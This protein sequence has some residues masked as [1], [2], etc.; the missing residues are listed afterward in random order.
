MVV[1]LKL[2]SFLEGC[3]FFSRLASS[4]CFFV[5][6]W[7]LWY[8]KGFSFF[9]WPEYTG[10]RALGLRNRKG[11]D[12]DHQVC[13]RGQC[14]LSP[15]L[16][17]SVKVAWTKL[18][19]DSASRPFEVSEKCPRGE[20]LFAFFLPFSITLLRQSQANVMPVEKEKCKLDAVGWK[21]WECRLPVSKL[22]DKLP[23]ASL[24][25]LVPFSM[26]YQLTKLKI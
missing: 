22:H 19:M 14:E 12:A 17:Q 1:H 4:G 25:K 20:S 16:L 2:P 24:E 11:T 21:F 3:F 5:S 15:F 10:S 6:F 18:L 13:K 26:P 8:P 9:Y 7:S 23:V